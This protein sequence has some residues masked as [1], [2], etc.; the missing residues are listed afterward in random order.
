MEDNKKQSGLG[1]QLAGNAINGAIG[2]GMGLVFGGIQDRRQREQ[3]KKLGEIQGQQNRQQADYQQ[4]LSMD[5]M[6]KYGT[7]DAKRKQLEDAG[8]SVGLMYGGGGGGGATVPGGAGVAGVSGQSSDGGVA[9]T[10]MGLQMA[11]QIALLGAQKENIEAD[12]ANKKAGEGRTKIGT[13]IDIVTRDVSRGTEGDQIDKIR[14]EAQKALS[15]G[16][17]KVKENLIKNSTWE[18]EIE[19]I[20]TRLGEAKVSLEKARVEKNIK[21]EELIIKKFEAELTDQGIAPGTPWYVKMLADLVGNSGLNPV[22]TIG[23]MIKQ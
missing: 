19:L 17:I 15:E 23:R 8:L 6:D 2:Q 12:T 16:D 7:Q 21:E 13:E 1:M 5:M 20:K 14:G 4:K 22:K 10:A 9:R 11:S 18:S 3:A